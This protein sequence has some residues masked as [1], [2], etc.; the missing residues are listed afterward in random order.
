MNICLV[1]SKEFIPI[2]YKPGKFCSIPCKKSYNQKI[3]VNCIF[4]N[5]I[6]KVSPSLEKRKLCSI[7]C[8]NKWQLS[9]NN[10]PLALYSKLN[11]E[12]KKQKL[13]ELYEQRVLKRSEYECW[14]WKGTRDKDNYG[15]LMWN[16]KTIRAHRASYIIHKGEIPASMIVMHI[17]D[18]PPCTN[19]LH[20][21]S[22]TIAEN[23]LDKINKKRHNPAQGSSSHLSIL[24][25]E[26]VIEIKKMLNKSKLSQ[27]KIGDLFGVSQSSIWKIKKGINW[28]NLK[29]KRDQDGK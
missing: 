23:N 1:C 2:K 24:T 11:E 25:Y 27:K 15:K 9:E 16:G 7:D 10:G 21:K 19:P 5:K 26:Q 29:D 8:K 3:T 13:K 12:E 20:L 4:C 18:S 6:W 14:D 28:K 22:A 17:C